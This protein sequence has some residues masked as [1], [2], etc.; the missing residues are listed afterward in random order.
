MLYG[1]AR[2]AWLFALVSLLAAGKARAYC[3]TSTCKDCPR[4][5]DGCTVGGRPIAWRGR[6]VSLGVHEGASEQV[7]LETVQRLTEEAFATWNAVRCESG[8]PPSIELLGTEGPVVCGRSEFV[9]DSANANILVFR[10]DDWPHGGSGH[11]LASTTV[12]SRSSGEIVDADIEVNSTRPLIIGDGRGQP[13]IAGAHD[14]LSILT[15]ELGH[16]LGLDH[17]NDPDS[18]MQVELQPRV[19]RTELGEDDVAGLCAAYPP[20][21]EAP[22]CDPAPLGGFSAQCALDP[23]TGGACSVERVGADSGTGTGSGWWALTLLALVS[24]ARCRACRASRAAG[25]G[26]RD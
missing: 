26:A 12:R 16:L 22:P 8:E 13:T 1:G 17:S 14:L 6:C 5:E 3:L 4:D 10:D 7:D 23:S 15:H 21:R 25:R 2:V 11:E 24:R 18:I 19:V 9:G 20:E